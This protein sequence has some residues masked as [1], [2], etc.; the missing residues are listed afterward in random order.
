MQQGARGGN[1][2]TT[3]IRKDLVSLPSDVRQVTLYSDTCGGQNKNSHVAPIG[4][5]HM[6]RDVDY[7]MIEKQEKIMQVPVAHPHDWDQLLHSICK[8][9]IRDAE[10]SHTH[11]LDFVGMLKDTL[12]LRKKDTGGGGGGGNQVNWK[13]IIWF[14]FR[15]DYGKVFYK[16]SLEEGKQFKSLSFIRREKEGACLKLLCQFKKRKRIYFH[17]SHLNSI[18]FIKVYKQLILQGAGGP[19]RLRR[20][21]ELGPPAGAWTAGTAQL[22]PADISDDP[23]VY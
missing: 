2:I 3:C 12:Q 8:K 11:F 10:L 16:N 7:G 17:L 14:R 5:S 1:Q 22:T 20:L 19:T 21:H 18:I 13:I 6:E 15:K 23:A 4:H 9:K